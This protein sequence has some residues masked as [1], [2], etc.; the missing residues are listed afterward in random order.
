MALAAR[1][2]GAADAVDIVLG[3]EG[4]VEVE[5]MRQ[6]A[7]VDAARRHVGADEELQL[8][9]LEAVQRGEAGG[10]VHVPV[11]GAD[12]EAVLLERLVE[13][14]HVALAVAEDQ[15]VLHLLPP[16]QAAQRLA[17]LHRAAE[18]HAGDDGGRHRGRAGNLDLLRVAQEGVGELADLR[19][20]GGGE[21]QRL[22]QRGKHADDALDIG[23]EAH[24]QHPVGLVDDEDLAVGEQDA[25]TVEQVQQP[26]RRGDQ[27]VHALVQDGLL[28]VHALAADQQR[29]VQLQVLAVLHEVLGDLERQLARRL[30]DQRARH[31][32]LGARAGQDV[33]HRQDEGGRLAGAGLG[34]AEHVATHQHHGNGLGLNRR[35]GDV[36]G[37]GDALEKGLAQAEIREGRQGLFRLRGGHGR[38][39]AGFGWRP[40]FGFRRDILGGGSFRCVG[41]GGRLIRQRPGHFLGE[42]A[43]LGGGSARNLVTLAR[44]HGL[45]RQRGATLGRDIRIGH[46]GVLVELLGRFLG[47][48]LAGALGLERGALFL[49]RRG[50]VG[51]HRAGLAGMVMAGGVR[52]VAVV[53]RRGSVARLVQI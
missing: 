5:D 45:A 4:H 3:M 26:A 8:I 19:R 16:D 17:L 7:D 23:D 33:H 47:A 48:A 52:L 32:G 44:R 6:P 51:H 21:E 11:Q 38:G 41:G 46:H 24:V 27:H 2:A 39:L 49:L 13:D 25:A 28:L 14:V 12:R 15:R 1:A 53:R 37:L 36:A 35:R 18:H 42:M 20:H 29:V 22:A 9:R 31:A 50:A 40:G 43:G 10:L 34:H 30:Q